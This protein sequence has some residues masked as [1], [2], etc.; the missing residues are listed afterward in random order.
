MPSSRTGL[1]GILTSA[2]GWSTGSV[3][4]QHVVR[5]APAAAGFASAML[6]AGGVLVALPSSQA[7]ASAGRR[8]P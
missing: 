8:N 7:S 6:C 4:S 2:L 3:L 1:F 5:L